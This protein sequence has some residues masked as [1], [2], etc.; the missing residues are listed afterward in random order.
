MN[1]TFSFLFHPLVDVA[2]LNLYPSHSAAV[3]TNRRHPN[4]NSDRI[5]VHY[6]FITLLARGAFFCSFTF[7]RR[8][9]TS[10]YHWRECCQCVLT[11]VEEELVIVSLLATVNPFY[12]VGKQCV[13]LF[14]VFKPQT[15]NKVNGFQLHN[16]LIMFTPCWV[17]NWLYPLRTSISYKIYIHRV[18]KTHRRRSINVMFRVKHILRWRFNWRIR[19]NNREPSESVREDHNL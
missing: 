4:S 19:W 15:H 1:E 14:P 3:A 10:R 5:A 17:F 9:H 7:P 11:R 2:G 8:I 6:T 16:I 12:S 13:A 18:T